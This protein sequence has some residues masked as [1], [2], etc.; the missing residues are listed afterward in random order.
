MGEEAEEEAEGARRSFPDK[1]GN[2]SS[3]Q[4]SSQAAEVV[5]YFLAK[6]RRLGNWL[7]RN[8]KLSDSLFVIVFVENGFKR[9]TFRKPSL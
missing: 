4:S 6:K 1:T 7:L 3:K 2:V 9:I 5:I 8:F